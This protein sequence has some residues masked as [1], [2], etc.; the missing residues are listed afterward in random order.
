[1]AQ[2]LETG[3]ENAG[4]T[5]TIPVPGRAS[6]LVVRAVTA[7]G[8]VSLGPSCASRATSILNNVALPNNQFAAVTAPGDW[9]VSIFDDSGE[10]TFDSG[11]GIWTFNGTSTPQRRFLILLSSVVR[12]VTPQAFFEAQFYHG[13]AF[14]QDLVGLQA[15]NNFTDGTTCGDAEVGE[16]NS[17]QLASMRIVNPIA[18][19]EFQP[20]FAREA[21][22]SSNATLHRCYMTIQEV[23]NAPAP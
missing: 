6:P 23:G 16:V 9:A 11:T 5:M 12:P 18:G 8:A 4:Q 2:V 7:G 15:V 21:I 20:V 1:M 13:I 14:N 19:D 10:W 3:D 22:T 17:I